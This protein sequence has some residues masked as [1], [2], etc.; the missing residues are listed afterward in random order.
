MAPTTGGA[1][2]AALLV[3]STLRSGNRS[4]GGVDNAGSVAI[5]LELARRL[6]V[7]M[8]VDV[9]VI[10]FSPG[11]EEDHMVGAMRWLD[12]NLEEL[13]GRPLFAINLDGAGIPGRVVLLER[14]GWGRLFAPRLSRVA[15]RAARQL[16][17]PVRGVFLPPAMGVDAIPFAHRGVECLTLASGSLGRAVLAVHSARDLAENL[18]PEALERVTRLTAGLALDLAQSRR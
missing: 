14:Y 12:G 7:A 18:D 13:Q 16:G 3:L 4:P 9:E 5:V 17:I 1:V 15:R 8:P 6:P 10:F 2:A 11:A